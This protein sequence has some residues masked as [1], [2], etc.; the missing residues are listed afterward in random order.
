MFDFFY[1]YDVIVIGGGYV[2]I[3][4]VL[5]VV[6][7]G[8]CILLLIYN[9]EIIGVMSCN[10]VIGGIGKG[11]LVKEID[12]F[13]GVMVYVVDCVGIQWCIFNVFKGFVVCVMCCQVDC[14]LYCMVVCWMVEVQLNLI[15]FQVVVDDLVIEGDVVCGVII[16]IGLCFYVKV[17]VLIVGIFLVGK[18]YVGQIQYVVGCMGDLLVIILVVCLCECLFVVDWFKIGILLCIDGCL[19]DYLVMVEQ[20]GD[21]LCLVMFFLG[22]VV[23]YLVQV[24]CWIIYISECI[25]EI[26]CSVLY[27]LL[28]YSGQIEGIGL[29]YCFFIEDKVVCFVEKVSYQIFVEFEGLDVVEIYFNGIFILLLFD[30]QL[31]LVCS[32][33][34]FEN[35]Y[36]IWFG[37]VIEYDFFDLCGLNNILEI[38]SV[39][40]LFFV[41]QIN[42]IIGYE[43]V[44]VQGLFVGFN[45]V[46]VCCDEVGW[47]LCCDEVYLGVLVDDL[48]IYGMIELYCMFISCVEY[49]LQLC[50]DNVDVCLIGIGCELGVVDDCCWVV[51]QVKQEVVV[52]ELVCLWVLW[53]ILGN[54][55]GCEVE[56]I[57]GV[58]VSCEINVFDLIKCFELDYVMFMQVFLFGLVVDDFKVV[59]QVEIGVKYVGYLDCQCEEIECQQ[60]YENIVIVSDFD[61]VGVCGLLVEVQQKFECVCLQ[62]IGQVQCIFG[63]ILVV[64]LL[65]L[66]YLECVC[67]SCVV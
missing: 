65:L 44:G 36:I 61:Y 32:I 7:S 47:C 46:C 58:V 22:D 35:V 14:N 30:V 31:D 1:Y 45:V 16:Q 40:G 20:F 3:E 34:G 64:I 52:C 55:L 59:E 18:I 21:I 41:G 42:G 11:Y 9:V 50:E 54:V 26:I 23:D 48:I 38:K 15:V 28:L 39:F 33:V 49:C 24:S 43:E 57:L 51:F 27:C 67:C 13:G 10:L 5:V 8:V 53:V 37:Y 12:V 62:I 2:G 4:V 63:M 56:I 25:Y 29:C 60:C 19:L 66:V 6:C 17:V